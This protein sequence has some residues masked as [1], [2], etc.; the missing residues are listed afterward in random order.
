MGLPDTRHMPTL[1]HQFRLGARSGSLAPFGPLPA[2][3]LAPPT[4]HWDPLPA[5]DPSNAEAILSTRVLQLQRVLLDARSSALEANRVAQSAQES[6]TRV[7]AQL[8]V[9]QAQLA[10]VH[11]QMAALRRWPQDGPHD[12]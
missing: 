9:V 11:E 5:W 10:A 8:G 2:A 1:F 3:P 6:L 7:L 4:P 12:N